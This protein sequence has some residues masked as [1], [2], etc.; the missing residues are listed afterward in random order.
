MILLSERERECVRMLKRNECKNIVCYCLHMPASHHQWAS[1]EKR[2]FWNLWYFSFLL[3]HE[4]VH[5]AAMKK[6][7]NNTSRWKQNNGMNL[8]W[9]AMFF[10]RRVVNT[11]QL[12]HSNVNRIYATECMDKRKFKSEQKK[13]E[14]NL[15]ILW[16]RRHE[17]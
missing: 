8:L 6:P 17:V 15:H 4:Q 1:E 12:K 11:I 5:D 14:I 13:I 2:P 3:C 16:W 9:W 7:K 10:L